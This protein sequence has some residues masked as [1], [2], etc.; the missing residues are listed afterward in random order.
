MTAMA[1]GLAL[2]SLALGGG[3]TGSD[4]DHDGDRHPVRPDHL[5]TA[6]YDCGPDVVLAICEAVRVV[7]GTFV[8][9]WFLR[10][11]G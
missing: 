9:R 5:D 11:E 7:T 4:T 3:K 8:M 1:A 6:E 2:I 10:N